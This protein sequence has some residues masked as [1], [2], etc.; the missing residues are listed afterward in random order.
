MVAKLL[1]EDN[2]EEDEEEEKP[3]T[4][5]ENAEEIEYEDMPR[6]NTFQE[7]RAL[8]QIEL[9]NGVKVCAINAAMGLGKSHI[10]I[11]FIKKKLQ[12]DPTLRMIIVTKP[13][14]AGTDAHGYLERAWLSALQ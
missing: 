8:H 11:V 9:R 13:S 1:A 6:R 5:F 12:K 10:N 4:F 7:A 14:A 3:T 2:N